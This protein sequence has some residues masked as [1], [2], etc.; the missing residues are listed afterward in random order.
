MVSYHMEMLEFNMFCNGKQFFINVPTE[1]QCILNI[2]ASWQ[3]YIN[4]NQES[5]DN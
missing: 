3:G 2:L 4:T 5:W 1:E